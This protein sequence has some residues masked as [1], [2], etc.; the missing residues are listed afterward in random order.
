MFTIQCDTYLIPYVVLQVDKLLH[1][2][3][4][5]AARHFDAPCQVRSKLHD[6]ARRLLFFMWRHGQTRSPAHEVAAV[7]LLSL[8]LVQGTRVCEA[9]VRAC[10]L[11]VSFMTL[12]DGAFKGLQL[13]LARAGQELG[14]VDMQPPLDRVM[15]VLDM[16]DALS[17]NRHVV[18]SGDDA[19][20]LCHEVD[21]EL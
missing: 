11:C 4:Q 14:C 3:V 17:G 8:E 2:A 20:P 18:M 6:L 7:V 10:G 9:T 12:R 5:Q 16:D 1:S 19:V 13:H 15:F 21:R